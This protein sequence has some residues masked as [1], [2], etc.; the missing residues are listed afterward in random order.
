MQMLQLTEHENRFVMAPLFL[1]EP[2]PIHLLQN[3]KKADQIILNTSF[4]ETVKI[5]LWY[6]LQ[7]VQKNLNG[8]MQ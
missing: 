3:A 6:N 4:E 2:V 1:L 5:L 7:Y 8:S